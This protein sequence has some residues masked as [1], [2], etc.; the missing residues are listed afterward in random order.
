MLADE[1]TLRAAEPRSR[2]S[3]AAQAHDRLA[4]TDGGGRVVAAVSEVR[5]A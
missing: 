1:R 4:A 5:V 3:T 2:A